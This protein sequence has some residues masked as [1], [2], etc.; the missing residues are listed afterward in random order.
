MKYLN[1]FNLFQSNFADDQIVMAK[2][3]DNLRNMIRK[4]IEEY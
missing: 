3:G 2:Y 4:M 1:D